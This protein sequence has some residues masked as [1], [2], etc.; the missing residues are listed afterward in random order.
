MWFPLE[1]FRARKS[2]VNEKGRYLREID[3]KALI[4]GLICPFSKDLYVYIVADLRVPLYISIE[5][6]MNVIESKEWS[7]RS[8]FAFEGSV[9]VQ[10]LSPPRAPTSCDHAAVQNP[11]DYEIQVVR[12]AVCRCYR[13]TISN[14]RNLLQ[15]Y[16]CRK[17]ARGLNIR[18][19]DGPCAFSRTSRVSQASSIPMPAAQRRV[20]AVADYSHYTQHHH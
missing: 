11:L 1:K 17:K 16:D 10:V 5:M 19:S 6:F 8:W 2:T 15:K 3:K 18:V 9:C 14:P 13:M 7:E 12:L 4:T 20:A